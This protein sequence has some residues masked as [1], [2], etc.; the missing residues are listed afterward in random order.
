M[1]KINEYEIAIDETTLDNMI[2][3]H[4][5]PINMIDENFDGYQK[6]ADGDKK[7]LKHLI[8]AAKIVNDIALEQDHPLNIHLK[9]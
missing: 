3:N 7:A 1:T 2:D 5:M 4:M 6:L 9:Q 8:N